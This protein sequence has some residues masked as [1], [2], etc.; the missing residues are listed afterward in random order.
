MEY[1]LHS[2][3]RRN[4][5][6]V[7]LI[8][9]HLPLISPPSH[10]FSRLIFTIAIINNVHRCAGLYDNDYHDVV[11]VAAVDVATKKKNTVFENKMRTEKR[12]VMIRQNEKRMMIMNGLD[13]TCF[14]EQFKY[15]WC[16]FPMF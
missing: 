7:I 15:L 1:L 3:S 2:W 8:I 9:S 12:K 5:D 16:S 14:C 11:R 13:W 4:I 10:L 6:I